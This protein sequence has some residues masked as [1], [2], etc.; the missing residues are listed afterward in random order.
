MTTQPAQSPGLP[1]TR[2]LGVG[3]AVVLAGVLVLTAAAIDPWLL[4]LLA[5]LAVVA[6]SLAQPQR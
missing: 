5:G 2:A 1:P 6:Y 4:V 3:I